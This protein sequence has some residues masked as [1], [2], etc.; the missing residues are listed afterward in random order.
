MQNEIFIKGGRRTERIGPIIETEGQRALEEK[1]H[2]DRGAII[3]AILITMSWGF[4]YTTIKYSNEGLAPIFASTVRSI[5]ASILGVIYCLRKG[6]TLFHTDIRLFH[7]IVVGFFFGAE[8]AFTYFG[9]LYTDS[10]RSVVFK[11]IAPFFIVLGAHFCLKGDRLS[12]QKILGLVLAFTGTMIIFYGKPKSA[13]P[14][15]L[16]G[17]ILEL[18]GAFAAAINAIYIKRFMAETVHPINTFLYQLIFS[19][20]ILLGTSYVLELQWIIKIDFSILASVLYQSVVVAFVSYVIWFTLLHRYSASRL[21]S[22]FFL[23]PIFGVISGVLFLSEE[24][25]LSLLVGVPL[26]CCGVILVNWR[27]SSK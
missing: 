20:P 27:T 4:S 23:A 25:T 13:Q 3:T 16:L 11:F 15:M 10:T 14:T 19:I 17:D 7:G 6:E 18:A 26:T 9:L 21:Y 24:L 22:F 8:F 2:L 5:I 12:A 1:G